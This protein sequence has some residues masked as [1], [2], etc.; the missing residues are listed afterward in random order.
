MLGDERAGDR[1]RAGAVAAE[2][3]ELDLVA[4]HVEAL[5]GQSHAVGRPGG[6]ALHQPSARDRVRVVAVRAD[7][8]DRALEVVGVGEGD[9]AAVGRDRRVAVGAGG[10]QPALAGSV[11]LHRRDVRGPRQ[12]VRPDLELREGQAVARR[13]PG[14][15][16]G[17]VLVRH[18]LEVGAVGRHEPQSRLEALRRSWRDADD[19]EAQAVRRPRRLART[20]QHAP[21]PA[22]VGVHDPEP[23]ALLVREPLAVRRPRGVARRCVAGDD[24]RH[25]GAQ[26]AAAAVDEVDAAG[27]RNRDLAAGRTRG[28]GDEQRREHGDAEHDGQGATHALDARAR[29]R[30]GLPRDAGPYR[31]AK[32]RFCNRLQSETT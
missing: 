12:R 32:L 30:R 2:G 10:S 8:H 25:D 19:G 7:E 29:V 14:R 5:D 18:G 22:A 6:R 24:G 23:A 11:Q 27:A 21:A 13:E 3:D 16:E 26:R 31:S 17:E 9:R 20:A 1:Q 15:R 28:H 4:P